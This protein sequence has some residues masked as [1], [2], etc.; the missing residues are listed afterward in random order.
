[1]AGPDQPEAKPRA[2]RTSKRYEEELE[3]SKL[4]PNVVQRIL[5]GVLFALSKD[6][7]LAGTALPPTKSGSTDKWLIR[8]R[9]RNAADPI[10][11]VYYTF[12]DDHVTLEAIDFQLPPESHR[13]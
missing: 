1:M 9:R 7:G 11:W 6:P 10:I 13:L 2:I 4:H 3:Q 8:T 5:E 12:D